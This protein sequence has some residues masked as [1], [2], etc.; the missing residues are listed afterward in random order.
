MTDRPL[1]G[2]FQLTPL[3]PDFSAD[4]HKLLDRLRSECP[5]HHD[6]QAGTFILT[7]HADVRGVLSDTTMWR[8][9]ERAEEAALIQRALV[10]QRIEGMEIPE[11]EIRS[12]ILLM[13][14]PDHMRIRAPFAKAL[15]KR[16]AKARVL[17]EAVAEQWLAPLKS[18]PRFDAM[19][20]FA[21]R[22]PID[23]VARILGVDENRLVQFRE[24]SEGAILGLNPFRS[25]EETRTFV[26]CANALS[27]Y[28]GELMDERA[29]APKDDLVSDMMRLQAEG[30]PLGDGE[31]SNN[32]QG[33]LVGG[34]LT[35]T[36]LI[37]NA[38]WLFL[39]H[40]GELEKLRADPS[41]IGSA[42]EEVLRYESPV[43]I[44]GRIA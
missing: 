43:D 16:V 32:L 19:D 18:E 36:D 31:I 35:T 15:Y 11:D 41:L 34:N 23:V 33:L 28:M 27:V 29:R 20:R 40:P 12:G 26:R 8:S 4:P 14:E 13:D 25:E 30:A 2:V 6:A 7:R 3:N 42:V 24:W 1:P 44:T 38:I 21:L 22:V 10:E 37:G 9:P 17:V 5:V 39:S